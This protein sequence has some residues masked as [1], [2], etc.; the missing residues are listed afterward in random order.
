MVISSPSADQ[1]VNNGKEL[2]NSCHFHRGH[3]F[4]VDISRGEGR[5]LFVI[6]RMVK[7]NGDRSLESRKG[8]R[9]AI[10]I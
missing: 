7:E 8:G 9:M 6:S 4:G 3:Y 2:P 10:R 1:T 5:G